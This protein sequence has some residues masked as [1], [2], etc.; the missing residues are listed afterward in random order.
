L[1]AADRHR[2]PRP[3]PGTRLLTSQGADRGGSLAAVGVRSAGAG[4]RETA[5]AGPSVPGSASSNTPDEIAL[6]FALELSGETHV[7]FFSSDTEA[8]FKVALTWENKK[9]EAGKKAPV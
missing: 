2:A 9:P 7:V 5:A 4:H 1:P 3:L 6:E 8:T